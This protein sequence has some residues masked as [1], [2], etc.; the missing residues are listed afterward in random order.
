M[1]NKQYLFDQIDPLIKAASDTLA[2]QGRPDEFYLLHMEDVLCT[3]LSLKKWAENQ[4]SGGAIIFELVNRYDQVTGTCPTRREATV[5]RD[6]QRNR[7]V[8][9][10]KP[11]DWFH[12]TIREVKR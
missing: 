11:W 6:L 5:L 4:P 10:D 1:I 3:L 2:I 12:T 9:S 7:A 8:C